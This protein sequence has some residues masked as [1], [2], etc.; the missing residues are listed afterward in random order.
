MILTPSLLRS[1]RDDGVESSCRFVYSW[2]KSNHK[3]SIFVK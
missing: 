3:K 2:Q 1:A